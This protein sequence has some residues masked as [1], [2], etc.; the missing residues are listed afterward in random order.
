MQRTSDLEIMCL[1]KITIVG[2][3]LFSSQQVCAGSLTDLQ[4]PP[5]C[6]GMVC[7][8]EREQAVCF[9]KLDI[10]QKEKSQFS[11]QVILGRVLNENHTDFIMT[12]SFTNSETIDVSLFA[13]GHHG[14]FVFAA[15]ILH[16]SFH[17]PMLC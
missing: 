7:G 16:L 14:P 10:S 3:L 4:P 13:F 12:F 11:L 1:M 17:L 15:T 9:A 8:I 6:V 2:V 5:V